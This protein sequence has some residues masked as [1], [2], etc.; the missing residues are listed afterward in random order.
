MLTSVRPA[1]RSK[2]S[3]AARRVRRVNPDAMSFASLL[4]QDDEELTEDDLP[5]VLRGLPSLNRKLPLDPAVYMQQLYGREFDPNT[6]RVN[7]AVFLERTQEKTVAFAQMFG[8][9]L[10]EA[11]LEENEPVVLLVNELGQVEA[12]EHPQAKAITGLFAA[13]RDLSQS[14]RDLAEAHHWAALTEMGSAYV[15]AWYSTEDYDARD[16]ISDAFREVFDQ[17]ADCASQMTYQAGNLD[18]ASVSTA[19]AAIDRLSR[20]D[21]SAPQQA[22]G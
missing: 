1:S 19:L 3:G 17:L 11:G 22:T 16:D 9:A 6:G 2:R 7:H 20:D 12:R 18:S 8:Q 13:D 21:D 15:E 4:D 10:G 14:F 5:E